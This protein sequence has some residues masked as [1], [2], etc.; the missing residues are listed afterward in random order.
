MVTALIGIVAPHKNWKATI[1]WAKSL[2][3]GGIDAIWCADERDP[4]VFLSALAQLVPNMR[5]GLFV[6]SLADRPPLLAARQMITLDHLSDGRME[7]AVDDTETF[8]QILGIFREQLPPN[9]RLLSA[10]VWGMNDR[11]VG[12]PAVYR[13]TFSLQEIEELKRRDIQCVIAHAITP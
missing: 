12:A 8:E 10:P 9:S 11:G 6:S 3:D 5:V 13:S 1:E 2:A 4:I 7:I